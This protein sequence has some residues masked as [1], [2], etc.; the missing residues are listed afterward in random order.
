MR[1]QDI[2]D[3]TNVFS[4]AVNNSNNNQFS[5]A[6]D[7]SSSRFTFL[8]K[9]LTLKAKHRRKKLINKLRDSDEEESTCII[10]EVD[11]NGFLVDSLMNDDATII[12]DNTSTNEEEQTEIVISSDGRI[13]ETVINDMW[14]NRKV[15]A[16]TADLILHNLNKGEMYSKKRKDI[17]RHIEHFV[18]Q[19]HK[20]ERKCNKQRLALIPLYDLDY[21]FTLCVDRLMRLFGDITIDN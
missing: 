19:Y 7:K 14:N 10:E 20:E 11:N 1:I 17:R 5:Y 15:L 6:I 3:I 18:K 12:E 2:S 16:N 13:S 21:R 8:N 4:A 9:A